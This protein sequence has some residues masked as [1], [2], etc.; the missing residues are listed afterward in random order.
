[1]EDKSKDKITVVTEFGKYEFNVMPFG[2][3][4][5]GGEGGLRLTRDS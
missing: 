2:L 4:G 1:M 5:R 3:G